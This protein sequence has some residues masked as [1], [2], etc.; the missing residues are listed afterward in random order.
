MTTSILRRLRDWLTL[1]EA[2][3]ELSKALGE[4][5]TEAAV[6]RLGIDNHLALSLHLPAKVDAHCQRL[7]DE[8]LDPIVVTRSIQG[9]CDIPILGRAKLELEHR[10]AVLAG[11]FS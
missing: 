2:A 10:C 11:N 4:Q 6:I 8:D 3:V 7:S 1:S 5:V 9:L